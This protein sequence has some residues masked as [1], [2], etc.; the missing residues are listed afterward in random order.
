MTTELKLIFAILFV[1]K[2]KDLQFHY[3]VFFEINFSHKDI[4]AFKKRIM[5][6]SSFRTYVTKLK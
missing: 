2:N 6:K 1:S 4:F 3:F 5:I